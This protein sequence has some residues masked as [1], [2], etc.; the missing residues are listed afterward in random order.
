M[1]AWFKAWFGGAV[2]FDYRLIGNNLFDKLPL[3]NKS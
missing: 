3:V 2:I 1:L